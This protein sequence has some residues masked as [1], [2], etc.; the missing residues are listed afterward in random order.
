[1]ASSKLNVL[2]VI[3]STF[4]KPAEESLHRLEPLCKDGVEKRVHGLIFDVIQ[5]L[6][7]SSREGCLPI[8]DTVSVELVIC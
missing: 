8:L 6:L 7:V 2:P 3:D 5:A 1:M 4:V